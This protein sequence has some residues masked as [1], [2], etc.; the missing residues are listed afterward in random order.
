MSA[1]AL[2]FGATLVVPV[3]GTGRLMD[4]S[5]DAAPMLFL[6]LGEVVAGTTTAANECR[7][8]CVGRAVVSVLLC[9]SQQRN[10]Q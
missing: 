6:L 10:V 2:A 9:V 5:V 1:K 7:E 8:K 4:L 3:V